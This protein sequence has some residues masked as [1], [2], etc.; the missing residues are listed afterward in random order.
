MIKSFFKFVFGILILIILAGLGYRVLLSKENTTQ[1][2]PDPSVRVGKVT[3]QDVS[4][5]IDLVGSLVS[6]ESVSVKSRLDSQITEV[7]IKDG[8]KV[9][10]GQKL[11]QLDDRV[12][13][14]Q[15]A[16]SEANLI[17]NKAEVERAQKQFDR[18]SSLLKQGVTAQKQFDTSKQT[19][20][21]AKSALAATE[22]KINFYKTQIE[23]ST[24]TSP[25]DGRVG[26]IK[27]TNGNVVKAN[28]NIPL[29]II[30]KINPI[31][32]EASLP[33]RY[34]DRLSKNNLESVKIRLIKAGEKQINEGELQSIDNQIDENT[35]SLIVRADLNNSDEK[36]WPGMFVDV[37]L[38]IEQAKNVITIPLKSVQRTQKGEA[39]FVMKDGIA[40]LIPIKMRFM[41][42]SLVVLDD[43]DLKEG[44]LV[45]IEGA[46]NLQ[47]NVKAIIIPEKTS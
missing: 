1:K 34:F 9:E 16:E 44:D 40:K 28:D 47:D 5:N 11:F 41:S 39:V 7:A 14:A 15:L 18:D 29:V 42:E 20:D 30:N 6:F 26:S 43:G 21:A 12:L 46:F 32:I 19:L 24:I 4:E 27:I 33:Q 13:K 38:T 17:G 8:D 31:K 3:R 36:L 2:R 45:V 25:I 35:R 22:A 23:F 37:S 10:R